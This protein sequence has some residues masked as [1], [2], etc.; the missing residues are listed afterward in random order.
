MRRFSLILLIALASPLAAQTGRHTITHEDVFLM[1]R[2]AGPVISPDGRWIVFSVSEPSY[3]E[4]EQVTDLW[5]VPTDGSAQ[6]RR[7]TN[8]KGG[9]SGVEWSPDG[10]RIAFSARREG[11]D[12]SQ[13][14]L[15]DLSSGGEA[16]RVTNLATGASSPL[17]RPDGR[18]LVFA[19]MVYPGATSDSANRAAIAERKARKYNARVF[20]ASPIRLW[21]HWLDD[22]RPHLFVQ[23]LDPGAPARDILAGSQL[24]QGSGFGG[25]LGTSGEDL[26]AAWTPD[27]SGVVFAATTNRDQWT[28]SDVVQSLWLVRATGG[29][30][31][32]LT[33]G[34]DDYDTPRFSPDG[35]TLYAIMT[36]TNEH[37]FNNRRL[38]AWSWPSSA[39]GAAPRVVAGGA[40]HSVG[41]YSAAPDNRTIFFLAEDAGHTRLFR[42]AAGGGPAGEQEVGTMTT[43]G[44]TFGGLDVAT[45]TTSKAFQLAAVW[46]SA[47]NPPEVARIDPATGRWTALSKFNTDRAATIDW[48]PLREF[49]FTSSKGKRIHSFYAVPP[50]FDSTKTY[51]L[52]VLIHGG[53][54]SMWTDNFG[55]RWNPHLLGAAG[56]VV[57]MTDYRG[58]TGY[59]E[60]FSQDIQFDPLEGPANDLNEAA[61]SAIKRFRFIDASRQV[62]GGA[63][64]GGHLTNWLAVTTTRYRALVSHAG[65]WDLETQW[66]TS[67]FNYDRERNVGGPPW[68]DHPIWKTQSPMRFAKNLHT[69]V[70]VSVGERDFRVPMNNALEFWTALQRQQVPSRLI[71]WPDE[72]H[73]VLRG[74][75]SRYFY[76]EVAAW[77]ARWLSAPAQTGQ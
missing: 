28:R 39:A 59:G 24:V 9:E 7:L 71:I 52:F 62:A 12:A 4:G 41:T 22:R 44:G 70:L 77:F 69:P 45:G 5:L 36:P 42:A 60:T 10:R 72:N 57:L 30:P 31:Q 34:R 16:Q 2:V 48:R 61:D 1:K 15:L 23:S 67:D 47:T 27:G 37:T 49:W 19:S 35:K 66:A 53:A 18:A 75:D 76:R 21:D 6:P 3:A 58:S 68:E 55:L 65:E 43:G 14:Y 51:P 63:S 56:Y 20:D 38:V 11:D 17:W 73:W 74:E 40:S 33:Q 26:A 54:A 25:Q 64:Y 13:I 50:G 32:K 8:T 46:E 29:E